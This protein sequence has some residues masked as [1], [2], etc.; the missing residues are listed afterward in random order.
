M[1]GQNR[2]KIILSNDLSN[3]FAG[4]DQSQIGW[5][6]A[7]I[8]ITGL[9]SSLMVGTIISP[10]NL[11]LLFLLGLIWCSTSVACFGWSSNSKNGTTFFLLCLATRCSNGIGSALVHNSALPLAAGFF[12]QKAA[13]VT[14]FIHSCNGLGVL[15][16]PLFGS[17]VF[18]IGG[19]QWPFIVTGIFGA[20]ILITS[21]CLMPNATSAS[22]KPTK[23][24]S[25]EFFRLLVKP[26]VFLFLLPSV[27][28][29][30]TSGFKNS[31]F[32]RYYSTNLNISDQL[33]GYMFL[34]FACGFFVA[35]PVYG[36]LVEKGFGA[37]IEIV[38][39]I[40]ASLIMFCFF[41]PSFISKLEN[42]YYILVILFIYGTTQSSLFNPHYLIMEKI[43]LAEGYTNIQEIK[44]LSASCYGLMAATSRAIGATLFGGYIN[45]WI[46]Y[47]N[48][49]LSYACL[50]LITGT[51]QI[52]F[53]A[54]QGLIKKRV[55]YASKSIADNGCDQDTIAL[56]QSVYQG[57]SLDT[58]RDHEIS[59][60]SQL[61]QSISR[62][63][64]IKN[65]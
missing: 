27:I 23:L 29:V 14:A 65:L 55:Y 31:S 15:M 59:I 52:L 36:V 1:R 13:F 26:R 46:G 51:W 53:L 9:A 21:M 10:K 4:L 63:Y 20:I 6:T 5:V 58:G 22:R 17:V 50:L 2:C 18:S 28:L 49:C 25:G 7:A 24:K 61:L 40:S 19:Y 30:S 43:S 37:R 54:S 41:L 56:D 12:P 60:K 39:Q 38:A 42:V 47:Y 45:D 32:S 33:S 35:A 16:G 48:T 8:E 44:T 64:D 57:N 3:V 34:P 62:S 11:R